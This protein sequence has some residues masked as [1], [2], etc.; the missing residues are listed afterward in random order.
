MDRDEKNP[1]KE[2]EILT[3]EPVEGWRPVFLALV[4]I[5]VLYLAIVL[6]KTL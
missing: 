6:A 1:Q 2:L 4:V 3:H 5:G